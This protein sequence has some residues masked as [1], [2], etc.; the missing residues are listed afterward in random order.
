MEEFNIMN[1]WTDG[2]TEVRKDGG[3]GA[4]IN[5]E[6]VDYRRHCLINDRFT[7]FFFYVFLI[8]L[9]CMVTNSSLLF[10]TNIYLK[11][12]LQDNSRTI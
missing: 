6:S 8:Q 9:R 4:W 11:Y 3:M 12:I 1:K 5:K 7:Q 2:R 10:K